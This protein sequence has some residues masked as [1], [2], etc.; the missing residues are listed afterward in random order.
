MQLGIAMGNA[1]PKAR[2]AA[3][4]VLDVTN[5]QDGVAEAIRRFV[6]QVRQEAQVVP[7]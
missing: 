4:V 5:D 1:G 7:A 6:L 2:A 3:N